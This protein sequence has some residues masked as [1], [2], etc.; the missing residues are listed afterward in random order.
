[1]TN[2]LHRKHIFTAHNKYSKILPSALMNLAARVR[3]SRAFR[4]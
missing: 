4:L 2:L 3:S 1:M